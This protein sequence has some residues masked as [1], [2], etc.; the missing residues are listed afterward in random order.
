MKRIVVR[1]G[2]IC[3]MGS[4]APAVRPQV[5]EQSSAQPTDP[6]ENSAHLSQLRNVSDGLCDPDARPEERRRWADMLLS[7]ESPEAKSLT[8]EMLGL[9]DLDK[10]TVDAILVEAIASK[11]ER[12]H[13]VRVRVDR[14]ED[15]YKAS[16]TGGQGSGI[17]NSM[18]K[19]NGFAIIP[20]DWTHA[21]AGSR[22]K[23]MLF[24]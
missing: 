15:Q 12:R 3:L 14:E 13:Y 24:D 23:V 4:A 1:V 18:V 17:L 7:Y 10:P 11:D 20:E 21:P 9:T 6:P 16:P 22:V 2:L 19:A 5:S 8:V